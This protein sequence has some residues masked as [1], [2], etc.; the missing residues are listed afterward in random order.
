[1]AVRVAPGQTQLAVIPKGASST[2]NDRVK[3]R[4]ACLE[5]VY[6]PECRVAPRA[7]VEA[8]LTIRP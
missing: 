7:S 2:A 3:P 8:M 5:T 6:G 1:M 4:S